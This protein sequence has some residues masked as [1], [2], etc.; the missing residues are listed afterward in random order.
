MLGSSFATECSDQKNSS[1]GEES[2]L[3][4]EQ[5]LWRRCLQSGACQMR[6]VWLGWEEREGHSGQMVTK[7]SSEKGAESE[8][9]CVPVSKEWRL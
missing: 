4:A 2:A 1:P 7:K 6:P 3:V 5:R 9:S 8:V